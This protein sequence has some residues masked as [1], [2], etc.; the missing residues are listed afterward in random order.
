VIGRHQVGV[1]PIAVQRRPPPVGAFGG[2]LDEH[3]GVGVGVA[4]AAHA[5]LERHRHQPA[6]RLV[7][8]GAVVVAAD[9]DPVPLQVADADLKR[10]G[11]C[12]GDL[13]AELVA[14]AGREQRHAFR[15]AEAVVERLHPL[16]DPLAP[17]LP[18]PL[19]PLAVQLMGVGPEY[20][21]AQPL[22]RLDLHPLRATQPARRLHRAHVTL[23]RLGP[24]ELLRLR[25]PLLGGPGLE[26]FQQRPGRQLG[27]RVGAPQRRTPDLAGGRVQAL[28]HRAD[29]L[30]RGDPL[31]AASLGGAADEPAW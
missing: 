26:R 3:V 16:V 25:H 5:V 11:P 22:D 21:A 6:A 9:P 10:L 17:V 1:Q 19:E 20:L 23:E 2:V 13:P 7:T 24:G 8:V 4:G 12:L 28:E 15:G 31:Q 14:T 29:L 18:G 27:A 30:G